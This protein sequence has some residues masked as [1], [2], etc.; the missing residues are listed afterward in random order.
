MS[1]DRIAELERQIASLRAQ[2][3]PAP[4]GPRRAARDYSAGMG[5]PAEVVREMAAAVDARTL[6][7]DF[8]RGV[9]APSSMTVQP[10]A[11]PRREATP[12]NN[13][14]ITPPALGLQPGSKIIDRLMDDADGRD[15][16][17]RERGGR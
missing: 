10:D 17:E 3:N 11:E 8:R 13:G 5:M 15:R 2:I 4:L 12:S 9:A 14:W 16:R 1:E 7:R 6:A